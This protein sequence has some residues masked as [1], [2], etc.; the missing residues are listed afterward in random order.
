M[1]TLS[2]FLGIAY[3]AGMISGQGVLNILIEF[4]SRDISFRLIRASE[5]SSEQNSVWQTPR[6]E[7]DWEEN[8][9]SGAFSVPTLMMKWVLHFGS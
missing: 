5:D 1:S 8:L 9:G 3:T 2:L 6:E 4:W 7:G